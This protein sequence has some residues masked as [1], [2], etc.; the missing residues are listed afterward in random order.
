MGV[1]LK[2]FSLWQNRR[3]HL[4]E[5]YGKHH[6]VESFIE[7]MPSKVLTQNMA[8][9]CHKEEY[10]REIEENELAFYLK[11]ES[12]KKEEVIGEHNLEKQLYENV[13]NETMMSSGVVLIIEII[14]GVV[15]IIGLIA[16]TVKMFR[17]SPD[18]NH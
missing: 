9:K 16:L 4:V 17:K 12:A 15:S 7:W 1:E 6:L 13:D 11:Q 3:H 8:I 14:G 5:S 10:G 2:Y 18:K